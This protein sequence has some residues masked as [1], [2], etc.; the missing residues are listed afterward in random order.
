MER[1]HATREWARQKANANIQRF[2]PGFQAEEEDMVLVKGPESNL[3]RNGLGSKVVLEKWTGPLV[4]KEI[5]QRG[6]N[7]LVTMGGGRKSRSRHVSAAS[8]EPFYVGPPHPRHEFGDKFAQCAWAGRF[9]AGGTWNS[10]CAA[11]HA[12][13][14]MTPFWRVRYMDNDWEDFSER[15][16]VKSTK[17]LD[18]ICKSKQIRVSFF[19]ESE[20]QVLNKYIVEYSYFWV[21][22]NTAPNSYWVILGVLTWV[23]F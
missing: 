2:S 1:W 10:G 6:L 12:C 14:F 7:M 8:N 5:T 13:R 3:H 22:C 4:V 17:V 23:V 19:F 15:D 20:Y 16:M 9:G 21:C 11:L 18:E